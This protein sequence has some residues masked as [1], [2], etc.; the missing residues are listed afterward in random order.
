MP[1][2]EK[3][4][5]VVSKSGCKQVCSSRIR[6]AC[7][8]GSRR[9]RRDQGLKARILRKVVISTDVHNVHVILNHVMQTDS[10]HFDRLFWIMG[11]A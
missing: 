1:D 7:L 8:G 4:M 3:G 10:P 6:E 9:W 11:E 5:N 2:T